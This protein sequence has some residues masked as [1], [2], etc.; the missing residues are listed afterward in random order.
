MNST[1]NGRENFIL[2]DVDALEITT[3]L[4]SVLLP[5]RRNVANV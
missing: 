5:V 1:Q 4:Y 2:F 3:S